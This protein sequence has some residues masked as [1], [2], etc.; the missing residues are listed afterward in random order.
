MALKKGKD[1]K[2][3]LMLSHQ[4]TGVTGFANVTRRVA[5]ALDEAGHEVYVIG[6]NYKGFPIT[7]KETGNVV[8]LPSGNDLWGAD[9]VP[10][11]MDLYKPDIVWTLTDIWACHYLFNMQKKWPW[12]WVRHI[13]LDTENI[14]PWWLDT[15]KQTDIPIAFSKMGEALMRRA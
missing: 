9:I 10:F 15:L 14:T 5:M 1:K 8:M 2:T 6:Q 11:Y 13:T 3:V 7:P 12:Q 4:F